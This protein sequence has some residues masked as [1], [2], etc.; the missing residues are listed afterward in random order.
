MICLS[1]TKLVRML[2]T[3]FLHLPAVTA[4][5]AAHGATV[6]GQ[7]VARYGLVVVLAWIGAGHC[8]HPGTIQP[9]IS[10]SPLLSWLYGIFNVR[11]LGYALGSAEITAA[12]LIALRPLWP[13]VSAVGSVFAVLIFC[14]TISFL[15]TTPGVT[16]SG[17]V[18]S[19]LGEFLIKDIALLGVALWTLGDSL[20][21]Q[22]QTRSAA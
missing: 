2:H 5:T 22:R 3:R 14:S 17:P 9:L 15:F 21:A 12:L 13:R 18:L 16:T 7:F 19:K 11:T 8:A 20:G 4:G 10:H 1:S 6:A